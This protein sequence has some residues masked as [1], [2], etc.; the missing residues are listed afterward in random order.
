[1]V[2]LY[3]PVLQRLAKS[4]PPEAAKLPKPLQ[5]H[6]DLASLGPAPSL[7]LPDSDQ[8]LTLHEL[9]ADSKAGVDKG[10]APCLMDLSTSQLAQLRAAGTS[11][12]IRRAMCEVMRR[13]WVALSAQEQQ[14]AASEGMLQVMEALYDP[15]DNKPQ[16]PATVMLRKRGR[17]QEEPP[18]QTLAQLSRPE[19]EASARS[20]PAVAVVLLPECAARW[21]AAEAAHVSRGTAAVAAAQ[22]QVRPIRLAQKRCRAWLRIQTERARQQEAAQKQG[23]SKAEAEQQQQQQRQDV[24][25][26]RQDVQQRSGHEQAAAQQVQQRAPDAAAQSQAATTTQVHAA[27][28]VQRLSDSHAPPSQT[29]LQ[30][31]SS[32]PQQASVLQQQHSH[33]SGTVT[34]AMHALD[35][36]QGLAASNTVSNQQLVQQPL[37]QF[38]VMQQPLQAQGQPQAGQ[39]L[40]LMQPQMQGQLQQQVLVLCPTTGQQILLP[41]GMAAEGLFLQAGGNFVFS[42]PPQQQQQQQIYDGGF[43]LQPQALP[44]V[45]Q[46]SQPQVLVLPPGMTWQ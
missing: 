39:Q 21:D 36:G 25:Q 43:M 20:M 30:Q 9:S 7:G 31:R 26:Q 46:L 27:P 29:M 40:V 15:A 4:L 28:S 1:V 10:D 13:Q 12:V 14:V 3:G 18:T 34:I 6:S 24:Q 22:A 11:S 44:Q 23:G 2:A 38:M 19:L 35:Q 5:Q 37:Q 8:P 16:L 33:S 32:W 17:E 42:Q 41:Q 45:L